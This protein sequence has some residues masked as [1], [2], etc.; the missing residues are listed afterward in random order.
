MAHRFIEE[1]KG[2]AAAYRCIDCGGAAKDWSYK[3]PLG[4]SEDPDD[5][6]PRCVSCHRKYD[7]NALRQAYI[8]LQEVEPDWHPTL[9]GEPEWE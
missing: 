8:R 9:E 6:K 5:Y 7:I 1:Q 3:D 2:R 4:F